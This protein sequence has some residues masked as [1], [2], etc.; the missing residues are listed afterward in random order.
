MVSRKIEGA[1]SNSNNRSKY[2]L[3]FVCA[4]EVRRS[5]EEKEKVEVHT[6]DF[7]KIKM[8]SIGLLAFF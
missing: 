5:V 7:S 8:F 3:R 6:I 4:P 1:Y 2:S